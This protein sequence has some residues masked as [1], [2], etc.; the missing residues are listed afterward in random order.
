MVRWSMRDGVQKQEGSGKEARGIG[1][2][3]K[4]DGLREQKGWGKG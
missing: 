1:L 2:G 3:R 4:R